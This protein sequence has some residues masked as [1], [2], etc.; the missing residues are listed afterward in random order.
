MQCRERSILANHIDQ[1]YDGV[2]ISGCRWYA[3]HSME[4]ICWACISAAH[5]Y[6]I[7]FSGIVLG[8]IALSYYAY[9]E[10]QNTKYPSN[11]AEF[12]QLT[13]ICKP[14]LVHKHKHNAFSWRNIVTSCRG[15]RAL[16]WR[17]HKCQKS[18]YVVR[19]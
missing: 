11:G 5:A 18:I 3:Q 12:Y 8:N 16:C 9:P 14:R 7:F 17:D 1:D 4:T 19:V 10:G 15:K 13:N 2:W 6:Q